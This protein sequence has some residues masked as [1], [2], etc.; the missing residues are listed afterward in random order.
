MNFHEV[1]H[2]AQQLKGMAKSIMIPPAYAVF[3]TNKTG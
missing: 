3:I 2:M 1:G